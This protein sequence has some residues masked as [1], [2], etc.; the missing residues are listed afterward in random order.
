VDDDG[1]DDDEEKNE[2][3]KSQTRIYPHFTDSG[4]T[5]REVVMFWR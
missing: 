1:D 4:L 2:T 3:V 5:N